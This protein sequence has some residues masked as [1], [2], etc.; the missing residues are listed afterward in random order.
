M[1]EENDICSRLKEERKR[2]G[3][4]QAE[5]GAACGASKRTVVEWE[6]E[7]RIPSD[8][9]A[10]LAGVGFD[11]AYVLTGRRLPADGGD[12]GEQRLLHA[13]RQLDGEKREQVLG[14]VEGLAGKRGGPKQ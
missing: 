5:L 8:R 12:D 10:L 14:V 6:K 9:L 7:R 11:T 1:S 2:L 4:T 3:L 13:F